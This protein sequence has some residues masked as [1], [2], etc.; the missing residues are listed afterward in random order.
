MSNKKSEHR[1][2][3]SNPFSVGGGG[4][5]YEI[6]VQTFFVASMILGWKIINLKA[7]KVEKIKL[8]GR[9]EGYDTDDCIVFGDNGN[10]MLCQIKHSISIT[11][12]DTVLKDVIKGAW[13]D[14]NNSKLFNMERDCIDIIVSG[15]S[16]TDIESLKTI[17]AWANSCENEEEFINKIYKN[18]FSSDDKKKKFEI[19]K[20]H[21]MQEKDD[22][23]DREIW[24]FLKIFSIS[25]LDVD[26][27]NSYIKSSFM[28]ALEILIKE[29]NFGNKLYCYVADKN[30]NAGTISLQQIKEELDFDV[31]TD[32]GE[33]KIDRQKL[34]KH[35]DLI[36]ENMNSDVAGITINRNEEIDKVN[37]LLENNQLVLITG[38]R[39][40]GKSGI[41]KEYWKKY[42]KNRY[43][44]AIRTEEFNHPNIQNVFSGIGVNSNITDLF[45]IITLCNDKVIFIESLEK[46][47][48]LESNRAFLDFLSLIS[49]HPEWKIVATTRNYAVQQIIMNFISEYGIKYDIIEINKF[50]KLQI[51]EFIEKIPNLKTLNCNE[52]ILELIKNPFYLSS[53]YKII[54]SGYI[55]TKNDTK[56]TIKNVI[57]EKII[58]K[59]SERADGLPYKREKTFIEIALKRSLAM[60]Y[61]VDINEFDFSAI[62]K[63]EEDGLVSI[64]DGFVY[65]THD[66]FEDWAIENYIEKQYKIYNNNLNEFFI[67]IGCEQSM[68]RAYRLWLNEKD[69]DF[70]NNYIKEVFSTNELKNIWYDETMSAIIFSNKLGKL[71]SLLEKELLNDKCN[72]LKRLCFMIRVTAKKPNMDLFNITTNESMAKKSALITLKPYGESWKEIIKFLYNK[73]EELSDNMDIHCFKILKEWSSI[74]NINEELP[75]ESREAGLLSLFII[76]RIKDNYSERE[77]IKDIFSIA[78]ITYNSISNEFNMFLENTVF[79]DIERKKNNYI[80]DIAEQ[81]YHSLYTCF[82]AKNNP[83]ILIK[84]AKK[85]WF[86]KE[87]TKE[88]DKLPF[89]INDDWD[90]YKIYG[91]KSSSRH[92][93]F[94]PSGKREPFRSLFMYCPKKAIDFVI[95]LCNISAET[96]I[97]NS[98]KEY[99]EEEKI[100]ILEKIVY[101]IKKEDGTIIKQYGINS[102][103]LAYRGM[104]NTPYLIESALMALENNLIE[105]FEYF[106]DN[107]KEIEYCIDYILSNSNSV[108]TTSVLVSVA[109]PYYKSLGRSGLLLLQ[110]ND[111]YDMDIARRVQEMGDKEINWFAMHND[112]LKKIYEEDRR[113]AATRKWREETLE[114]LCTKLQFTDLREDVWKVIDKLDEKNKDI[115][116]WK[117]RLNRIDSRKYKYELDEE[118]NQIICTSGEI[119]DENLL[120]ISEETKKK[121]DLMNRFFG[122]INWTSKAKNNEF[123]FSIYKNVNMLLKEVKE[124]VAIYDNLD[125]DE[126]LSL[127]MVGIIESIAIIYITFNKE[128]KE[129]ERN[130]CKEFIINE[131]IK[132]E[133]TLN[134]ITGNGRIDNTGLW[135]AAEAFSCICYELKENEKKELLTKG[136]T[137]CDVD[138]RLHTAIGI[139][140]YLWNV[141]QKL[142]KWC[143]NLTEYFD[144]LESK[145]K[146]KNRTINYLDKNKN[147]NNYSKWLKGIRKKLLKIDDFSK[148]IN[149]KKECSLYSVTEKMMMLPQKYNV[150]FDNII[151]EILNRIVLAE[152]EKNNYRKKGHRMDEGYF[153]LLKYYTDFFGNY[154]YQMV[155]SDLDNY[156][157]E[158]KEAC[159]N[160]PYFMKWTLLQYRLLTEK[161]NNIDKYWE[162]FNKILNV[163]V[164]ISKKIADGE[165]YKYDER[166]EILSEYIYLNMPWQPVDF[167]N[168]PI[169]GGVQYICEFVKNSNINV[170]VFEGI[171]SLMYYFSELILK[172]GLRTFKTLPENDIKSNLEKSRNSIFYLEN[173][174]HSYVMNLENNTISREMYNIC[175]RILNALIE[176]AS[177][178]AYYIREYLM[179]SKKII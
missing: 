106:K 49:K 9:Y 145:E 78:M 75:L 25:I 130:W 156:M 14:F 44:L 157:E 24:Q 146:Q 54:N 40:I 69:D 36:I 178:K 100:N 46:I 103:W 147:E 50:S 37:D 83:E 89:Y 3:I 159:N 128:L 88:N 112:I 161:N 136:L 113:K 67:N 143:I 43:S 118:N 171:S 94:P 139:G 91:L 81:I 169:R 68:C 158:I 63:L 6:G 175:E 104:S 38:E 149:D 35:T 96:Y 134:T 80:D 132:Y 32:D 142:A 173:V 141:D 58:K 174:L 121:N 21:L 52:E 144:I 31:N 56:D 10:K 85:E 48:E 133:R 107:K 176:C 72:L 66:V 60:T 70:I 115:T 177:S 57:W 150:E 102:F 160:A 155:E 129:N 5:N 33:I 168:P 20:Y 15:L 51:D 131:F 64:K 151:L 125:G 154:F 109:I 127:Y 98:L 172:E 18:K 2:E 8:Q 86:I 122:I 119:T 166:A 29:D 76:D 13:N 165:K 148:L 84:V 124:L 19:I 179:K 101:E 162:F 17:N 11:K 26:T 105:H 153:E 73:R 97:K 117:F 79:N 59:N 12:S 7:E 61:A 41:A 87:K 114:S 45:N 135:T 111:F 1:A 120:K 34:Q 99:S 164:D 93:Y 82:I 23:T 22:L 55:L 167:K 47:L 152:E 90:E 137:S 163:M 138:I 71:L 27:P 30:Q 95:E 42:C 110:N 126:K 16:K 108:F 123:E 92:D 140:K 28:S 4:V 170:I 74:I 62:T 116:E 77:L 65:L 53:V 39:G